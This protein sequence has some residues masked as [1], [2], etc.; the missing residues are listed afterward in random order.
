MQSTNRKNKKVSSDLC[1]D[2]GLCCDGTLFPGMFVTEAERHLFSSVELSGPNTGLVSQANGNGCEHLNSC[3]L[4]N[5]YNKRP[6]PCKKFLCGVF[7][8]V[9]R[10]EITFEYAKI[11]I[12]D[13][14]NKPDDIDLITRF[15]D[16]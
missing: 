15:K 5:I 12:K 8:E 10:N 13:L 11:L 4:C 3:N 16:C 9:E 2:C 14:K 7:N 6:S 1:T